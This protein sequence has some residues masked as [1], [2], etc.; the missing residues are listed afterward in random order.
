MIRPISAWRETTQ[1]RLLVVLLGDCRPV[2]I[3]TEERRLR[4]TCNVCRATIL[5]QLRVAQD[6]CIH[7]EGYHVSVTDKSL[8]EILAYLKLMLAIDVCTAVKL[9]VINWK[10]HGIYIKGW[11]N[12][13]STCRFVMFDKDGLAKSIEVGKHMLDAA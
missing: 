12:L 13:T 9:D 5:E 2:E 1:P 7:D 8:S 6:M 11:M 4:D 10:I 3:L